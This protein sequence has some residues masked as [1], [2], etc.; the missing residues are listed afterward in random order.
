MPDP[1]VP[2]HGDEKVLLFVNEHWMIML[3]IFLL[4]IVG[5]ALAALLFWLGHGLHERS[6]ATSLSLVGL[7]YFVLL[8]VHHWF[9]M[10]LLSLELSGWVITEKR[11]IDFQFLPYMRHNMNYLTIAEIT[12]SEKRQQGLLKNLLHYGEVE[13]NLSASRQTIEFKYVPYP[14]VFIE[15]LSRLQE[16]KH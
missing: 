13:L 14:G 6:Q 10:Y 1:Q 4:Y 2:I 5:F 12:E 3:R 11:I 9:F 7:S 15:T 8:V 16:N